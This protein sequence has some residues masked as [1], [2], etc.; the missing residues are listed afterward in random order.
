MFRR[1]SSVK[2]VFLIRPIEIVTFPRKGDVTP[3]LFVVFLRETD[4]FLNK[5]E[6]VEDF[7]EINYISNDKPW[8]TMRILRWIPKTMEIFE[9]FAFFIFFFFCF[10]FSFFFFLFSVFFFLFSLLFS[11]LFFSFFHFFLFFFFRT[12]KTEK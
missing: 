7:V 12:L 6:I 4:T 2:C 9:D 1:F 10:L 11:F 8:K 5:Q 3:K